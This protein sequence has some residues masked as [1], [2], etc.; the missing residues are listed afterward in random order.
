MDVKTIAVI[1]AGAMGRSLAYAAAASGF[2]AILE[3]M[4]APRLEQGSA[5]IH[6]SFDEEVARG[7]VTTPQKDAAIARLSVA[8]SVE[9]AS[10]QA[11][12]VIEAA[13]EEM[14]LKIE[15]FTLLDKFAKPGSIFASTTSSLS[16]AEM[17]AVTF[18][19]E[20]CVGMHFVTSV[21]QKNLLEIICAPETS[22]ET[23]QSCREVG[24]RMGREVVVVCE[25]LAR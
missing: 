24:R 21:A 23:I 13:P 20:N 5:W 3:D 2:R 10:R 11:D 4:S 19:P 16:I 9:D 12:L 25:S 7:K 15:I 22:P 8:R 6:H 1:G 18:R 14:E 17:A